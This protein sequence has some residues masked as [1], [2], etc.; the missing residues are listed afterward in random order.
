M[1]N[2]PLERAFQLATILKESEAVA[3]PKRTR[4]QI[5]EIQ[6]GHFGN[7]APSTYYRRT[8]QPSVRKQNKLQ[9]KPSS[10]YLCQEQEHWAKKCS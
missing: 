10:C 8:R 3:P 9:Q 1:V 4:G 7:I 5:H 2:V 6:K